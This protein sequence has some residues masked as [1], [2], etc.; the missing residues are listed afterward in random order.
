MFENR[1]QGQVAVVTGGA[2][3]IGRGI[4]ARLAREGA[5]V[6]LL[7]LNLEAARAAAAEMGEGVSALPID[8]ADERSVSEA[9]TQAAARHGRLDI[10]VNCA[11]I[12]GPNDLRITDYPTE[13]FD[14]LISVNLRGSFLT[15]R[16][17]IPHML[18]RNYGRIL[19]LASMSGKEGNPNMIGYTA[20]KAGVIGLIKGIGKEYAETG[21]TVNG[22]A[23]ALI[24]TPMNQDTAPDTLKYLESRIP[25]RRAGTVDEV[26]ALACWIVS[27]EATFN[28]GVLFDLS[29]GRATY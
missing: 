25:M 4:A 1:F 14:R 8:V 12:I 5:R 19:L 23:P 9:F 11:G 7:D 13:T 29:G 3:G 27:P 20:S 2:S 26:A 17:A 22:M 16:Y 15:T 18:R 21:I 10:M 6:V 28:T 24:L